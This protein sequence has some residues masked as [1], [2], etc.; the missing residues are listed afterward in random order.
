LHGKKTVL[1]PSEAFS[2]LKMAKICVCNPAGG[3]LQRFPDLLAG[4][5]GP[6]S[7][8]V[9]GEG[10]KKRKGEGMGGSERA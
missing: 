4:L 5:R 3:S 2:G 7:K 9:D 1:L 10:R 8:G 6:T